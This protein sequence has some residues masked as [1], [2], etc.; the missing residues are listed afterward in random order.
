MEN[1]KSDKELMAFGREM[2]CAMANTSIFIH[3]ESGEDLGSTS[4]SLNFVQV[5]DVVD[6]FENEYTVVRRKVF[7]SERIVLYVL[8][9]SGE[10]F[11]EGN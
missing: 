8:P 6:W 9:V 4:E 2:L 3:S 1:K 11:P 10:A 5:G 7:S